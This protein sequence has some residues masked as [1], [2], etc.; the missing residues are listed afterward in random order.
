MRFGE[1]SHFR[2]IKNGYAA[3]VL[4][5]DYMGN[6]TVKLDKKMTREDRKRGH[7]SIVKLSPKE[8]QELEVGLGYAST[9]HAFQGVSIAFVYVLAGGKMQDQSLTY[10]SLSRSTARCR[11]YL[12]RHHAGAEL[13][14]MVK[15]MKRR[16]IKENAID[17]HQKHTQSLSNKE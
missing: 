16:S 14:N 6:A 10:V 2:G 13:C 1:T 12:D 4:S 5:I 9:V 11:L 3:T 17:I 8:L 7:R 15:A